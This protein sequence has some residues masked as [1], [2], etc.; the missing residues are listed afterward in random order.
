MIRDWR[1]VYFTF[2]HDTSN[3]VRLGL[4]SQDVLKTAP[5]LVEIPEEEYNSKGELNT[6]AVYYS[7]TVPVL[8]QAIRELEAKILSLEAKLQGA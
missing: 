6:M 8:V 5:E 2:N 4:V 1:T 3:K 7:E